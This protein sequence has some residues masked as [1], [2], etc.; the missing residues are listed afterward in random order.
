DMTATRKKLLTGATIL[1]ASVFAI[2]GVS[3]PG[4]GMLARLIDRFAAHQQSPTAVAERSR[5]GLDVEQRARAAH[6]WTPQIANSVAQGSISYYD[7][8]GVATSQHAITITRGYPDRVRVE[9]NRGANVEVFGFDQTSS[10]K[11]G[12]AKLKD[13]EARDI[14]AFARMCPE[15]LFVT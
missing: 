11:R 15:R 9:I 10:W 8:S 14:R 1:I 3:K 7:A 4:R 12:A 5:D 2:A 13:T 6:G